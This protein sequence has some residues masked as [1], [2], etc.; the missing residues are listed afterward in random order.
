MRIKSP[1]NK[2]YEISLEKNSKDFPEE[3]KSIT[4]KSLKYYEYLLN[5]NKE[6]QNI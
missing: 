4:T 6:F 3:V 2:V 5:Q 1:E